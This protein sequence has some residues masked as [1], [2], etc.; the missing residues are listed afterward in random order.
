MRGG[1]GGTGVRRHVYARSAGRHAR[2]RSA[3]TGAEADRRTAPAAVSPFAS[4]PPPH[5]RTCPTPEDHP[6][7]F[8]AR[9][10]PGRTRERAPPGARAVPTHPS[11][12]GLGR[13]IGFPSEVEACFLLDHHT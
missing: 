9:L 6:L 3:V 13:L 2:W 12:S 10:P 5:K 8:T 4:S 11:T 7:A 1:R